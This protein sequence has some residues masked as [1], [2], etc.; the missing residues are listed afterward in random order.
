MGR[1]VFQEGITQQSAAEVAAE[2][3]KKKAMDKAIKEIDLQ[4]NKVNDAWQVLD[5]METYQPFSD[6]FK[7]AKIIHVAAENK[8]AEMVDEF[9]KEYKVMPSKP[10][11]QEIKQ[12]TKPKS[13]I[14][15]S[16]RDPEPEEF[17]PNA[18]K[19]KE[20]IDQQIKESETRVKNIIK[21]L[22][23]NRDVIKELKE[24]KKETEEDIKEEIEE[25][26]EEE[27]EEIKEIKE[28]I[29]KEIKKERKN[30]L[31]K[32][33]TSSLEPVNNNLVDSLSSKVGE[34]PS[35]FKRLLNFFTGKKEQP[36]NPIQQTTLKT[37]D[38]E[39]EFKKRFEAKLEERF[40]EKLGE[41]FP[42][43]LK[44][45]FPNN[46]KECFKTIESTDEIAKQVKKGLE[47]EIKMF[48]EELDKVQKEKVKAVKPYAMKVY[49]EII[50]KVT[51]LKDGI[52]PLQLE[53][54]KLINDNSKKPQKIRKKINQAQQK[55]TI[56][57]DQP[58]SLNMQNGQKLNSKKHSRA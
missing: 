15:D 26:V 57:L 1:P 47:K 40:Q 51:T 13:E 8:H 54:R 3:E 43:E 42:E 55:A 49:A 30:Q 37:K 58:D 9:L 48:K 46:L 25:E 10:K 20:E 38:W 5:H 33:K 27:I 18:R 31:S 41:R 53:A 16:K 22:F 29:K 6:E 45:R 19:Q 12:E 39:A 32:L 4:Q 36:R 34:K 56:Y 7:V 24:I 28:G 35:F 2:A 44:A 14:D 50:R 52:E 21:D 23:P 17:G 11:K